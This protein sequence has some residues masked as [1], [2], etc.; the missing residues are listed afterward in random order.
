M[1]INT[2]KINFRLQRVNMGSYL[3][4]LKKIMDRAATF[5]CP[6]IASIIA[7]DNQQDTN[8]LVYL[9]IPNQLYMFRAMFSPIIT[10]T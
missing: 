3:Q 6:R 4:F 7:N 5:V 2:I 8:I 10:S 9:F 1:V